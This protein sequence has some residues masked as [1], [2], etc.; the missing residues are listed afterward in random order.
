MLFWL[1]G[2]VGT[3]AAGTWAEEAAKLSETN[4]SVTLLEEAPAFTAESTQGKINFPKDYKGKWVI[5]FFYP[6]DFL[7]VP[8]TEVL[9]LAAMNPEFRALNCEVLGLS[10]DGLS[11]HLGWLRSLQEKVVYKNMRGVNVNIPLIDDIRQEILKKF[12]G[13]ANGLFVVDPKGRIRAALSYPPAVGRN[14]ME[15]KRMLVALQTADGY[16]INTPADWQPGEDVLLPLPATLGTARERS[17]AAGKDYYNLDWYLSLKK[18]GKDSIP[19]APIKK[20]R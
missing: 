6:A 8:A 2:A 4:R 7:P 13:G 20:E 14:F 5:L 9:T 10:G 15:I 3:L 11:A 12:G 1:L 19:P 16:T 18:L 17:D